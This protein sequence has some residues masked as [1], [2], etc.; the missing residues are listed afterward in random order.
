[1]KLSVITI[2]RNNKEG[3]EQTISSVLSQSFTDLEYIIIDGASNDGSVEVIEKNKVNISYCIS[4]PDKGIYN[5]MNKGI[6]QA[7][8]EYLYFLNSGDVLVSNDVFTHMFAST[9]SSSFICG[10]FIWDRNGNLTKDDSYKQRDWVFSLYDIYAGFLA[11]Q[12][13]F[14]H[15]NMFDKYGLYDERLKI[16]SD[17]KLF[18]IAIGIQHEVVSYL[19]V[20][21]AIYNTDGISST[22]GG[23]VI[24]AEKQKVAQ[25]ELSAENYKKIDRLY[26]LERNGFI[27]DFILSKKWIHFIFKVF[28]KICI[29]LK[30]SKI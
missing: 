5:A 8:G 4:E 27:V 9:I 6:K 24:L 13:F 30:L 14:I 3:L 19:D 16:M 2:N 1:M 26:F 25:E 17:W 22:I 12:A 28:F 15:R 23:K 11:H 7:T 29:T 18:F 21:I 10:N 20:D